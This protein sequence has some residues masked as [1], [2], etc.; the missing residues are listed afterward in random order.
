MPANK[1]RKV[2]I[3]E[4]AEDEGN[5]KTTSSYIKP[6]EVIEPQD[7]GS[8][9]VR[10]S[11]AP[12][13]NLFASSK[14]I[15]GPGK[16][17]LPKEPSKLRKSFLAD[18]EENDTPKPTGSSPFLTVSKTTTTTTP[19]AEVQE[20]RDPKDIALS[21]P[22]SDL[23]VFKFDAPKAPAVLDYPEA[24]AA[25]KAL[26]VSELPT[27]DFSK[28]PKA[29]TNAAPGPSTISAP[30]VKAFDFAAAGMKPKAPPSKDNWTCGTCCAVNSVE[31]D[32]KC[33]CCEEP[34]P[35][36]LK[37]SSPPSPKLTKSDFA[38]A[39]KKQMGGAPMPTPPAAPLGFDWKAAGIAPKAKNA[40]EWSCSLCQ[41]VN[42]STATEKCTVCDHP[43][44]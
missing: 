9:T 1:T 15:F 27:F 19:L 21:M 32:K 29:S 37:G 34:I 28:P 42:P 35:E 6:A 36:S 2:I 44:K 38:A 3:E 10:T 14:P 13:N 12:P 39:L 7:S 11:P 26:P 30:A 4:V 25:A 20:K 41:I 8:G 40:G 17:S 33:V 16:S 23:P 22:V 5:E 31:V 24:R 18:E 43:K